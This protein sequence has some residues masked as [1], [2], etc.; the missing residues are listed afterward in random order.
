MP[1][2]TKPSLLA[3]GLSSL[4]GAAV[5]GG[6]AA[7]IGLLVWRAS[8]E[9]RL[10]AHAQG[11]KDASM[12]LQVLADH[13]SELALIRQQVENVRGEVTATRTEVLTVLERMTEDRFRGVDWDRE[14][15]LLDMRFQLIEDRLDQ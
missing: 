2:V 3:W 11:D 9:A 10:T 1:G 6:S 12:A 13:G 7:L 5:I 14:K 15:E 8:V 4:A